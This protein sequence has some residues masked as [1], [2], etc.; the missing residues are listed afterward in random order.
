MKTK[1]LF[2]DMNSS[3]QGFD[4]MHREHPLHCVVWDMGY[5]YSHSTNIGTVKR[6][7][8]R[9]EWYVMHTYKHEGNFSH[10]VSLFEFDEPCLTWQTSTGCMNSHA[11][12]GMG[13]DGIEEHLLYKKKRYVL[14]VRIRYYES[15]VVTGYLY[16][17]NKKFKAIY[18]NSHKHAI[19]INLWKGNVWG[20]RNG[21]RHLMRR[22]LN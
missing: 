7:G 2:S 3:G 22:V 12:E 10:T 16:R 20:V 14:S 4:Y 6:K 17:T 18:T 11:H 21:K 8:E 15:F 5:L 9:C 1:R 13:R 19:G